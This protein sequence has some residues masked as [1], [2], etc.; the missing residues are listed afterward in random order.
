M[1]GTFSDYQ[2]MPSIMS[3]HSQ[4][5]TF[6][7][8]PH[9]SPH[10]NELHGSLISSSFSTLR[11]ELPFKACLL[12]NPAPNSKIYENSLSGT[13]AV[14]QWATWWTNMRT[15]V[16]IPLPTVTMLSSIIHKAITLALAGK[17]EIGESR[18]FD[19]HHSSSVLW[20]P[21][22]KGVKKK[23]GRARHPTSSFGHWVCVRD[24]YT[25]AYK[26]QTHRHTHTLQNPWT[27]EP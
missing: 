11:P 13:G 8:T 27:W 26:T 19:G 4:L 22:L 3:Q 14:A 5:F 7:L 10:N 16:Q 9:H 2:H 18:G 1:W 24:T 21:C 12:E 15:W 25:C 6:G 17:A 20:G 23:R